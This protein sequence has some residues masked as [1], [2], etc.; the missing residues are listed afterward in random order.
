MICKTKKTLNIWL[1]RDGETLPVVKDAKKMRTWRLGEALA[2]RGHTVTWWTSNFFHSKKEKIGEGNQVL[3]LGDN[4]TVKFID[5]GTYKKNISFQRIKHH[6]ILGKK[7]A[8]LAKKEEKPDIIIS[9]LPTLEFPLEAIKYGKM[10]NVPVILDVR[11]MWP[12]IFVSSSPWFLR[13]FVHIPVFFY[14]KR[15][16]YCLKKAQGVCSMSKDLLHWALEKAKLKKDEDKDVFYLGYDESCAQ[17]REVIEELKKIPQDKTI[18]SYLGSFNKCNDPELI[19][20]AVK[21]LEQDQNFRG[22]FILAGDGD[23]WNSI[24][25]KVKN[26]KNVT[27][28]NWLNKSQSSYLMNLTD[29]SLIPSKGLATPNKLFE[30]LFFG[31][32]I[33]FCMEGESKSI[34]ETHKAG[35]F[36]KE[37]DLTSLILSLKSIL[38]GNTLQ[39]MKE[40]SRHLYTTHFTAH[41][42]HSEYCNYIEEIYSKY[43]I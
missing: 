11:D 39:K 36:Y 4:L 15:V 19:I 13:P 27:L 1:L 5:C 21:V 17:E 14:N 30:A 29:V 24:K 32:P 18:F 7:F 12:D 3:K 35:I 34:L 10:Y 40:N 20:Q 22:H 38:E 25:E 26:R 31:K 28:L 43:K 8:G 37:N 9:S 2:D 16:I 6:F 33:I 41:K 42:I 23:L